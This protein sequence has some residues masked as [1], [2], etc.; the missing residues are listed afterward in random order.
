MAHHSKEVILQEGLRK[1]ALQATLEEQAESYITFGFPRRLKLNSGVFKDRIMKLAKDVRSDI[2]RRRFPLVVALIGT[3]IPAWEQFDMMGFDA[4]YLAD[5]Y[6]QD[7][8]GYSSPKG[9]HIVQMNNGSKNSNRS[10]YTLLAS[11]AA[12]E[13]PGNQYDAAGLLNNRPGL[14]TR[15]HFIVIPGTWSHYRH[16]NPNIGLHECFVGG[17]YI[18]RQGARNKHIYGMFSYGGHSGDYPFTVAR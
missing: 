16:E 13:R 14:L 2:G 6:D 7:P 1:E 8:Q 3:Q 18:M 10:V 9:F 5:T 12:D 4:D 15:D 11:L 17:Q